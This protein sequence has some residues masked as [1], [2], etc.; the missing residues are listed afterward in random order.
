MLQKHGHQI[1]SL[2]LLFDRLE[3]ATPIS[4]IHSFMT[5]SVL[6]NVIDTIVRELYTMIL[7]TVSLYVWFGGC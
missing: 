3:N 1:N 7:Q 4:T 2:K 6:V 5:L